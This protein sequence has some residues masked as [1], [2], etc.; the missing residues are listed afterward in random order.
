MTDTIHTLIE[1]YGL[2]AVFAA[3]VAE[4]E[5]AAIL[6]GFFSHQGVFVP[7]QAFVAVFLGAFGGD[8]TFFLFGRRFADRPFVQRLRARP[9]F[10]R[11]FDLMQRYPALYV[12]GNR[13][14]Y[15]FRLVGGVAAGMSGIA[16]PKFVVLNA[17]SAFIW[18]MLFGGI[19]YVFGLGAE[20]IIGSTLHNHQR[21]LIGLAIGIVIG[22][23]GWYAAH[24]LS[25]RAAKTSRNG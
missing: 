3:C 9:G 14:V 5:T 8:A 13:Y 21:L 15:G 20:Q 11:A 18:T 16:A 19:G 12:I 10:D 4:G 25:R 22:L 7:W 23:A 6:A 24:R 1:Q 17:I 2:I